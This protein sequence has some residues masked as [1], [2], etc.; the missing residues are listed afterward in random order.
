MSY[1]HTAEIETTSALK[2]DVQAMKTIKQT[3]TAPPSPIRAF[4]A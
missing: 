3:R 4:A 1:V 2:P